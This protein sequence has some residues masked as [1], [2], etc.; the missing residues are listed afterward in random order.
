MLSHCPSEVPPSE[1]LS[2]LPGAGWYMALL[3]VFVCLFVQVFSTLRL[4]QT[5]TALTAFCTL[6]LL[7]TLTALTAF[8]ETLQDISLPDTHPSHLI[9]SAELHGFLVG[10]ACARAG[11]G[12]TT[13]V[14]CSGLH[15]LSLSLSNNG[16]NRCNCA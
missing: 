15:P 6:R 11:P 10:Q 14:E 7:Q 9:G 8:L 16:S 2:H 5:F 4:L 3:C 12:D 1:V 13:P